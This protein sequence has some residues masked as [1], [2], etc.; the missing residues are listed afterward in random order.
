MMTQQKNK[1]RKSKPKK[2]ILLPDP[3]FN[4]TLVTPPLSDSILDGITR[5]SLLTLADELGYKTE[6]RPLS[7]D[8]L[9]K[10]FRNKTISEAFGA[11]TAAVVAPIETIHING[12]DYHLPQYSPENL[13]N[14]MKHK[15]DRIRTGLDEDIYGWNC[16][17]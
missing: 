4:D 15:L 14:R 5:D 1:M 9:E 8:E 10:A 3:K 11:G 2:R 7:I 17:V 13:L 16:I 12:I 6:E